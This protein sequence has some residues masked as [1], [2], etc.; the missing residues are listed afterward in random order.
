M[1]HS[2]DDLPEFRLAVTAADGRAVLAAAGE[3]D[4][5]H[6]DEL[7]SALHEQLARGP[8]HLDLSGLTFMD[9]SGVRL[10]DT[11]MRDVAAQG[12]ALTMAPELQRAVRRVL[13]LTGML[14]LLPFEPP[15]P[16]GDEAD[17]RPGP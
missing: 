13:E 10:L 16:A 11:V 5:A 2:I 12:Q 7:M 15:V 4:I 3:L 1:P 14:A 8:V 9:S 17:E 6:T